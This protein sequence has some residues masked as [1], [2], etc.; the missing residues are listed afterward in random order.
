MKTARIFIVFLKI[1]LWLQLLINNQNMNTEEQ[2]NTEPTQELENPISNI[3]E[4]DLSEPSLVD[5]IYNGEIDYKSLDKS[6]KNT[7]LKE[8][9][10]RL[11]E[12]KKYLWDQ[13]WRD[14]PFFIGKDKSGN[15]IFWKD[16]EEFS[17]IL[18]RP[19]VAKERE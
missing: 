8:A 5:K 13:G 6:T 2:L 4:E 7:V 11:D 12:E 17:R 3:V 1:D 9:Y 14:R 16:A 18:K 15:E 19:H 10:S